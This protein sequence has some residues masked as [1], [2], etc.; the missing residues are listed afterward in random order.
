[1][2]HKKSRGTSQAFAGIP[3][4]RQ[5]FEKMLLW[6]RPFQAAASQ[7]A[8]LTPR[9]DADAEIFAGTR[10]LLL[11]SKEPSLAFFHLTAGGGA[12]EEHRRHHL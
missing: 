10:L 9:I 1:M 6:L 4:G 3:D 5:V 7:E 2:A 12:S 11:Q 8:P